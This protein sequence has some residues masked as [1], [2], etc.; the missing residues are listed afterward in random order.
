MEVERELALHLLSSGLEGEAFELGFLGVGAQRLQAR[1]FGAH[2][3]S[4]P[5]DEDGREHDAEGPY[6]L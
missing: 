2:Y 3:G 5:A 4:S 6:E 1:I